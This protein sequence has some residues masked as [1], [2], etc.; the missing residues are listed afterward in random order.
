M[1]KIVLRMLSIS[2]TVLLGVLVVCGLYKIGIQCYDFGYRVYTEP[3]VSES[4]HTD[5][6]VQITEDMDAKDLADLLEEK[7]LVRDSR[8]FFLQEKLSGYKLVPGVYTLNP[9]MTASELMA[10]MTPAEEPEGEEAPS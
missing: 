3:A 9:S 1:T 5:V 10:G 6:L 8:L 4:D 7:K 2:T